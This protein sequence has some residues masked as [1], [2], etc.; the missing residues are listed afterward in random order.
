MPT[1]THGKPLPRL[2]PGA[3]VHPARCMRGFDV[4]T[5]ARGVQ[6]EVM[7]FDLPGLLAERSGQG[8][9]LHAR[10]LNPQRPRMLHTIGFDTVYERAEGGYLYDVAGNRYAD[11]LSGFGTFGIGHN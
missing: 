9:D 1:S 4:H 3:E 11:F 6:N 10:Y 7:G 2:V 8:Y 5:T